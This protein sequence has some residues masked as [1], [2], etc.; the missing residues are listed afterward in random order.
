MYS[1]NI[2][3]FLN[4]ERPRISKFIQKVTPK[5]KNKQDKV[6]IFVVNCQYF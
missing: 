1:I 2:C 6:Q 3:H 5:I 4:V